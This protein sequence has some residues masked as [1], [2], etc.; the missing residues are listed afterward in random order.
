MQINF[1]SISQRQASK[2]LLATVMPRPIALVTTVDVAGTANAAP[3]SFFN[4]MST[5][6]AIMALGLEDRGAGQAKD[7]WA[8]IRSTGEFVIHLVDENLL[9]RMNAMATDWGPEVDELAET[10]TTTVAS[11]FVRPPRILDAPV[12]FECVSAGRHELSPSRSIEFGEVR[13]MHI[14]DAL[15]DSERFYV[16]SEALDL[17]ARAHNPGF[18]ARNPQF[19]QLRRHSVESWAA[20]RAST[21]PATGEGPAE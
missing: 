7:T 20:A 6:P 15:F 9:E 14:R 18:Y 4:C 12:A 17:V 16:D 1:D 19:F 3:F 10:G 11:S 8:N 2:L 5:A 21:V 13:C